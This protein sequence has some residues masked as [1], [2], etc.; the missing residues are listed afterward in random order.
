M[1]LKHMF[2]ESDKIYID[3]ALETKRLFLI[4]I[5]LFFFLLFDLFSLWLAIFKN[6]FFDIST[7]VIII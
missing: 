3:Y 6:F 1:I 7:W 2:K 4:W 5:S